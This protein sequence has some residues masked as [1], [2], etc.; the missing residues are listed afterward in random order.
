LTAQ[1]IVNKTK[2]FPYKKRSLKFKVICWRFFHLLEYRRFVRKTGVS[3]N[4]RM[5]NN[6]D[7]LLLRACCYSLFVIECIFTYFFLISTN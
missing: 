7:C 3:E 1:Y 6:R 4:Q 5:D 2:F